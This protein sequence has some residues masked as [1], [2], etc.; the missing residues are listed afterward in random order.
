MSTIAGLPTS[1]ATM[2]AAVYYDKQDIRIED[3]PKPVPK[4]DEVL[5]KVRRYLLLIQASLT[6]NRLLS[7]CNLKSSSWRSN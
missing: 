7:V 5:I 3:V 4:D 1:G 6:K 2:R